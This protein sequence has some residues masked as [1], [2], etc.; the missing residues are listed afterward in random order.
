MTLATNHLFARPE[1]DPILAPQLRLAVADEM[2]GLLGERYDADALLERIDVLEKEISLL[3]KRD[4]SLSQS[5]RKLD[6][7]QRLAARI[8]QDF[9]PKSMPR[10]GPFSFSAIYRPAHYVSGDLYD[11]RR[12]DEHHVGVYVADAVGHGMPAALLTMFMK[13]A[14]LTKRIHTSGGYDL[15]APQDTI[16]LLNTALRSQNLDHASFATAVYARVNCETREVSFARGGHPNPIILRPDGST[17][18]IT[19]DGSLLG[20]FDDGE[21]AEGRAKLS[22]GDRLFFYTD[23]VEVAF[24]EGDAPDP[25]RWKLELAAR[26]N[27]PTK[28]IL[29][30][31]SEAIEARPASGIA[32]DDLTIVVVEVDA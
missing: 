17:E 25:E 28:D 21:W 31:F 3:Q 5:M 32:R 10:V 19:A 15:L 2:A 20:V 18:E 9:L 27:R 11:V 4:A 30:D 6:E 26:A 22:A 29:D 14:L 24:A 8:Q 16:A 7:E 13:N 23:G 1:G 12:L